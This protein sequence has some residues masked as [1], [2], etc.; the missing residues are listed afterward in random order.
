MFLDRGG[1]EVSVFYQGGDSTYTIFTRGGI[2]P[3][4]LKWSLRQQ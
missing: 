4:S 3:T 2:D 1:N